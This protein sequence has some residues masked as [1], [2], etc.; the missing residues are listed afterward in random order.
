MDYYSA[1]KFQYPDILDNEFKLCDDGN[2]IYLK[3]WNYLKAS[4]PD[5]IT[6]SSDA[7]YFNNY[8]QAIT[9]RRQEYPPIG[10]QLDAILKYLQGLPGPRASEIDSI[11][12]K[13]QN[14]KTNNPLPTR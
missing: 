4:K 5:L 12:T 1:I 10:D 13:W 8:N 2:G 7:T 14:V 6:L 11:I 3:E 9:K